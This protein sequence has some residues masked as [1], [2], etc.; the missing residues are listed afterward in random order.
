MKATLPHSLQ[1]D[2]QTKFPDFL[3]KKMN[4]FYANRMGKEWNGKHI[5]RGKIPNENSIDLTSNDYLKFSND[6]QVLHSQLT[7]FGEIHQNPLMSASFIHGN[8]PHT[9]LENRLADFFGAESAILCQSGYAANLGLMQALVEDSGV[10]VYIDMMT[11]MSVWNGIRLG[12][13]KAI[14]FM[15]NDMSHLARR[16]NEYG[17]GI[18]VVDSVYSSNGSLAPLYELAEIARANNCTLIVDES[19]SFGTHG[20]HGKGLIHESGIT[21]LVLFR[22]A[23]LAKAFGSRAGII[24]CP[25]GFRDFFNITSK[26]QIFSSALMPFDIIGLRAISDLIQSE[27]GDERR[28]RLHQYSFQLKKLLLEKGIDVTES[29]SQII[30]LKVNSESKM[31]FL[32]EYLENKGIYGAP[33]CTPATAKKKPLLRFSLHSELPQ[34]MLEY[35]AVNCQ[36][37]FSA[38]TLQ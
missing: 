26:P 38:L 14:S 35:I 15:H 37:A 8:N 22:T 7:A 18:I 1:E 13:G 24:L 16:I 6:P 19:H 30:S 29:E 28:S 5:L 25:D 3:L 9:Q 2:L 17:A 33:F 21:D 20:R 11:H 12:N 32:K 4:D 27:T 34:D 23:S 36:K 31:M 10:P